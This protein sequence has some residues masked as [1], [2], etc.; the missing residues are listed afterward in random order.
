MQ[1]LAQISK[2]K[3]KSLF[4]TDNPLQLIMEFRDDISAFNAEKVA[5]LSGKGQVNNDIN[6]YLMNYLASHG[7]KT[8]LIERIGPQE[9]LVKNVTIIPLEAVIRNYTAGN[10]CKRYGLE[11]GLPLNPPLFEFFLK[12]DALGDPMLRDEHILQFGYA[13]QKQMDEIKELSLSVNAL[14]VPIFAQAGFLLVDFKLEF[15][16]DDAGHILLADELSP[17]GCRIWDAT[18]GE[19]FDKDRF[20]QDLGQVVEH[21]Q[22]VASRLC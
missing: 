15:G 16:L 10:L 4:K 7:I 20:R 6:T 22:A 9:A 18:T 13:T 5:Q 1:K 3:S 17:D 14:L 19:I 11:K 8:H 2:G 12:D 21:Y